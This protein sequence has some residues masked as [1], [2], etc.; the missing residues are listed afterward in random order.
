MSGRL[1][2][3]VAVLARSPEGDRVEVRWDRSISGCRI[4]APGER[5]VVGERVVASGS[6][7]LRR[8]P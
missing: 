5:L 2:T 3:V 8:A 7:L 1:G 4:A 6:D